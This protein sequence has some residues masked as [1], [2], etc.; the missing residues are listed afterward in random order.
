MQF[1]PHVRT[2]CIHG[3]RPKYILAL[4]IVVSRDNSG[5][6]SEKCQYCPP[7]KHLYSLIPHSST[8]FP[9]F[10]PIQQ[11]PALA[12]Q[13]MK[14]MQGRGNDY[15]V[16]PPVYKRLCPHPCFKPRNLTP[17]LPS[18]QYV[19]TMVLLVLRNSGSLVSHIKKH[20]QAICLH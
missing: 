9:I 2:K 10:W 12:L 3:K 17:P 4:H 1:V 13:K 19:N 7:F 16:R 6:K 18:L 8:I 14:S 11:R 20:P 15:P 5:I